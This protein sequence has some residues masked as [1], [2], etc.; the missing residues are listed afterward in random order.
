MSHL[1]QSRRFRDVRIMS[2][3]HPISDMEA[4][5]ADRRF[6]PVTEVS[7]CSKRQGEAAPG[8]RLCA[9]EK[10]HARFAHDPLRSA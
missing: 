7:K 10:A 6:V 2:V 3:L 1:S 9:A 8:Y 4:D 5:I